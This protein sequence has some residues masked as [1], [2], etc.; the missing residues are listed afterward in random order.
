[1]GVPEVLPGGSDLRRRVSLVAVIASF[2]IALLTLG[3]VYWVGFPLYDP[4]A[5]PVA[6]GL[7]LAFF[8]ILLLVALYVPTGATL[9]VFENGL[10]VRVSMWSP[11]ISVEW[12]G[13][14]LHGQR[15]YL[16]FRSWG[17]P[18]AVALTSEQRDRIAERLAL[19]VSPG[20]SRYPT[21]PGG[22]S[23][24]RDRRIGVL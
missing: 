10:V 11:A 13:V 15:A 8:V 4:S 17:P 9:S 2:I 20:T 1:M 16:Y 22:S 3:R 19:R 6:V 23:S 7:S 24:V 14:A 12:E 21:A 5:L 18:L